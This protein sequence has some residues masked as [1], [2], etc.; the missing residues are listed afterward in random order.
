MAGEYPRTGPHLGAM[1]TDKRLAQAIA[2]IYIRNNCWTWYKDYKWCDDETFILDID[3]ADE[4]GKAGEVLPLNLIDVG[5]EPA[6]V[7][8]TGLRRLKQK[9]RNIIR[10]ASRG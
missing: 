4:K 9:M 7:K 5:I 6:P 10:P 8:N 2:D 3:S 1:R